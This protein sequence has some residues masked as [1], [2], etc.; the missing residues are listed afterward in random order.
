[1]TDTPRRPRPV[2]T[3]LVANRGEIAVRVIRAARELNVRT[4]AVYGEG[5]Q[6]ALHVRLADDAWRIASEESIPYLDIPALLE[7]AARSGADAVHPGYGFLAENAPF[8]RACAEAGLIFVGPS[9]E[10]IAAMGDKVEA[11][12][13]ALDAGVPLIPGS[14]GPVSSLAEAH[15]WGAEHGYPLAVKAAGGGGGRGFRVARGP[16]ELESAFLGASGEAARFF[17]NAE[18]YLERYLDD[19]RHIEIQLMADNHGNVVAVGS[20][21]CSIQRRHQK[22]IEEAPAPGIHPETRQSMAD[23]AVALGRAVDYRG[24]GTVEFLLDASGAFAFLEMNTRIQ[25]EHPVTEMT[26]GID[27]VREQILIA[28]GQ[29]LSFNADRVS[30]RGHAIEC[31][32]NAEDPGRGFAPTPGTITRFHAPAGM[33]VRVDSAMESGARIHPAYDSLIAKIISWG[34]DREEATSRMIRALEELEIEGVPTTR[35]FHLRVLRDSA[36]RDSPP[37]TTFLDRYPELLPPAVAVP[38]APEETMTVPI[39]VVAEVEGHRFQVRLH[40][41]P[42]M[43]PLSAATASRRPPAPTANGQRRDTAGHTL[44]SPIQGTVVRLSV[45]PGEQVVRGQTICVVEAMKMENDVGAHRD[46]VV[47]EIS[48]TP[49]TAVRVG[50]AL[51]EIG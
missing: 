44:R 30:P 4:V 33:G 35:D 15:A 9:P 18:V 49:G 11:R 22:L 45:V 14:D 31:R 1:M 6:D 10:A 16:E 36:W 29:Q 3:L 20:R 28:S 2:N 43:A 7:V 13:L 51:A 5:E 23:A 34:R 48:A 27:L 12:R 39:A 25:V 47:A 26:T 50:D 21:D 8:A 37:T 41:A 38:T 19:P 17:A 42:E 24:A 40:G 32:I 46:G